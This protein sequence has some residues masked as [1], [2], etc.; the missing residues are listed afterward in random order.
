MKYGKLQIALAGRKAGRC[1]E[2]GKNYNNKRKT[3][4]VVDDVHG[5]L[6]ISLPIYGGKKQCS[7]AS[8]NGFFESQN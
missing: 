1:R 7:F 3:A 2:V 6:S 5:F 4:N 8:I